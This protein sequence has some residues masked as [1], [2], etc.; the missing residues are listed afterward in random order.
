VSAEERYAR[1][2]E[3]IAKVG[4]SVDRDQY[5]YPH[6]LSG[7][8]RQR[9]ALARTLILKPRVIL[10]DEPFGA[11]DPRTRYA[12]QDLLVAL[13]HEVQATVFLVT[14]SIEEA[15]YVAD[16]LHIFSSA[17]GTILKEMHVPAP[18]RPAL[19]MQREPEFIRTVFEVRDLIE[20]LETSTKP[21]D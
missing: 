4:L 5:K 16:R 19:V 8:M 15:V 17:P 20:T 14:H 12:M 11:L 10:M 13:A 18:D 1:S 21:G 7:G 2:R 9:V 6:Q 3:W